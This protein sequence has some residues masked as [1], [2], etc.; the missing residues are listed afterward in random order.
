MACGRPVVVARAGAFPE[1]VDDSVGMLAEPESVASMADAI[2]GLYERDL[3]QV[4]AA[5][6]A[7]VLRSFTWDRAFQ[8]QTAAYAALVGAHRRLFEEDAE[9]SLHS[10]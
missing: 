9:L 5:A 7:R 8:S 3:D 6:R 4:G 10:T 2:T 1:L